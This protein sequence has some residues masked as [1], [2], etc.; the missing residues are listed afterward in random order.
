MHKKNKFRLITNVLTKAIKLWLR[1]QVSDIDQLQLDIQAGDRQLISGCIPSVSIV[2]KSAVYQGLH[3]SKVDLVAKNIRI[4]IGSVIKG[5]Q[6]RLLEKVPVIGE[7]SQREED[8]SASL[9]SRLLST[10]LNDVLFKLLPELRPNS[11]SISWEKVK[12]NESSLVITAIM[13]EENNSQPLD[14]CMGLN[15]LSPHE[16]RIAPLTVTSNT[17]TLFESSDGEYFDLGSDVEIQ[18]L[19]LTNGKIIFQGIINVNP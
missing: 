19:Q 6:L 4:N 18:D 8:L 12:I 9:S 3:L 16:L 1:T 17:K 5:Q 2:A 14:I 11:K 15:L 10:A 13:D 7:L